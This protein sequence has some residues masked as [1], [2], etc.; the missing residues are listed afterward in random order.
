MTTTTGPT[1]GSLLSTDHSKATA[2]GSHSHGVGPLPEASR[3]SRPTSFD[4]ADFPVPHGREEEWR[5]APVARL[6]PLFAA[7]TDGVL[8]G[9]GVLTTVVEAPEVQVEI[10]ERDDVRLGKAGK[11]GDRTAAVAWASFPRA[12]I[13]TIPKEAVASEVTSIRIEG[14]EGAGTHEAALEPSATHLLC[15]LY[16]SP[17]PR[18]S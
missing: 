1:T 3:A 13:V 6:A 14:V 15:L 7:G 5:F 4:V 2:D 17:S 18:D 8:D 10:V 11:P 9:H 12:T 16:T